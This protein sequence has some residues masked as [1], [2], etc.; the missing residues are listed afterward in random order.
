MGNEFSDL[1]S[2][3]TK[4]TLQNVI[5]L[6]LEKIDLSMSTFRLN[7]CQRQNAFCGIL[8]KVAKCYKVLQPQ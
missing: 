2:H 4:I 5:T 7:F 8:V 1:G 3:A 6:S